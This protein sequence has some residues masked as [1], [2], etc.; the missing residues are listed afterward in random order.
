MNFSFSQIK[1]SFLPVGHTH[2]DIDQMFSRFS[3]AIAGTNVE[4]VQDLVL[5]IESAY[6]PKPFVEEVRYTAD[7]RDWIRP[8]LLKLKGHS[9][10]RVFKFSRN[11]EGIVALQCKLNTGRR[12][13][14]PEEGL[15]YLKN[16]DEQSE[17]PAMV[18][19]AAQYHLNLEEILLGV[20]K[21]DEMFLKENS[22]EEWEEWVESHRALV[23]P[24]F[25]DH[26]EEFK[27]SLLR[28][29]VLEEQKEEVMEVEEEGCPIYI[30]TRPR[31][32]GEELQLTILENHLVAVLVAGSELPFEIGLA[33]EVD[34]ANVRVHW[35]TT[36]KSDGTGKWTQL[37]RRIAGDPYIQDVSKDCILWGGFDLSPRSGK[38]YK[39]D[40]D[41]IMQRLAASNNDTDDEEV[42]ENL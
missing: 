40:Y 33:L 22:V 14:K 34:E 6:K 28:D 12:K 31:K 38:L 21:V 39:V 42:D 41:V 30:G 27:Q 36:R 15:I 9:N 25:S 37:R 10:P 11:D 3:Y 20:K 17:L 19:T 8:M 26:W 29:V 23:V 16:K 4:S 5:R 35:Y 24:E 13:W 2:E 7:F 1:I 32:Q 18:P